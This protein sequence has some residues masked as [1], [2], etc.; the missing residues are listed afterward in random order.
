MLVPI[1]ALS[2][3]QP[4]PAQT[5]D[6]ERNVRRFGT[7][8]IGALP[9]VALPM[10]ASRN[11]NYWGVRLQ[12]GQRQGYDGPDLTT[13]AG[14]IDLQWRGGSVFGITGGYQTRSCQPA[15]ADCAGHALFGARARINVVTGGPT[16]A[17]LIGDY[18]ATTTLG[19][20]LGFGYANRVM[21][22]LSVCTLDLGAP[23]SVAMLQS[24]RLVSFITPAAVWDIG[25]SADSASHPNYLLN[26]GMGVQQIVSR[27]LDVYFG[28]QRIFRS[29]TGYQFGI[30]LTY[31]RLP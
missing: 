22:G 3:P 26:V 16:V 11:H 20:E 18:S 14:G 10:P 19:G 12:A 24:V 28:L 27:G 1:C 8:P 30:S 21:P 15:D 31:V 7:T 5:P 29:G 9:P 2:A 13:I 25:C 6:L 23:L 4:A 17:A